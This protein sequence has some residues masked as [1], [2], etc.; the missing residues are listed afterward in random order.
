MVKKCCSQCGVHRCRTEGIQEALP[1]CLGKWCSNGKTLDASL[2]VAGFAITA[3]RTNPVQ[4][5]S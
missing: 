4:Y 1:E 2:A 3:M 5:N